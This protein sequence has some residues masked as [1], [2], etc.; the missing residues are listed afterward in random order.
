MSW[1][2]YDWEG[3]IHA[4]SVT[5]RGAD[6]VQEAAENSTPQPQTAVPPSAFH[7]HE[8]KRARARCIMGG[9]GD[10]T[11]HIRCT[12]TLHPLGKEGDSGGRVICSGGGA[13]RTLTAGADAGGRRSPTREARIVF[14]TAGEYAV[15]GLRIQE[16]R[17]GAHKTTKD[18]HGY[19]VHRVRTIP[20]PTAA[21]A[22]AST[23]PNA[24]HSHEGGQSGCTEWWSPQM[25][26]QG[27]GAFK[28]YRTAE[29][30]AGDSGEQPT[31]VDS[32]TDSYFPPVREKCGSSA[33]VMGGARHL[34]GTR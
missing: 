33:C 14:Q 2:A 3:F 20:H 34:R 12:K 24:G 10:V 25:G 5:Q 8:R 9:G 21:A 15:E 13:P 7:Y 16:M 30:A 26:G 4:N 17:H 6:R 31:A 23:V 28:L 27:A 19:S 29:S 18:I 32:N 22:N 1:V 11:P